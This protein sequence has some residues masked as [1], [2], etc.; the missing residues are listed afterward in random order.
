[1]AGAI[2]ALENIEQ[3]QPIL[4]KIEITKI[5]LIGALRRMKVVA[6]P[7][8]TSFLLFDLKNKNID[9]QTFVNLMAEKKIIL[10]DC[11]I[12]E[13]LDKWK[14]YSA[15]PSEKDLPRIVNAIKDILKKYD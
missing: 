11:S 1:M 10:K 2:S 5:K 7:S 15:I 14:V 3:Y 6:F 8:Q 13:G 4:E 9:S 12:Y